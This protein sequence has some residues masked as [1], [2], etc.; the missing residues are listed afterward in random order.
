[1]NI[2]NMRYI[3]EVLR[4][5]TSKNEYG[6]EVEVYSTIH[7]LKAEVIFLNGKKYINNSEIFSE[8]TIKVTTYIR[9]INTTDIIVFNNNKYKI[10]DITPNIDLI[11]QTITAQ[12][13][14]D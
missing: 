11:F 2:G 10:I 8:R 9:D 13:I 1:M 4:K 6:E 14:N 5:S 3:V 7:K 12:M